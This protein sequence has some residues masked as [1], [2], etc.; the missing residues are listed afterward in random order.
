M[1][2]RSIK[3]QKVYK[4]IDNL[5]LDLSDLR[6]YVVLYKGNNGRKFVMGKTEFHEKFYLLS[7]QDKGD[8]EFK[9]NR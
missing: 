5:V 3:N 1:Y 2:Y 6:R 8:K 4:V 7:D 9:E